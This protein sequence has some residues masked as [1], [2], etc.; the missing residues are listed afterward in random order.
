[1]MHGQTNIKVSSIILNRVYVVGQQIIN[2]ITNANIKHHIRPIC[3]VACSYVWFPIESNSS[4]KD[5][6]GE[7]SQQSGFSC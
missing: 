3:T 5:G 7:E 1:M 2:K 6:A 4:A